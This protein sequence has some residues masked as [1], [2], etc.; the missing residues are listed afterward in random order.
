MAAPTAVVQLVP[1][2]GGCA[3]VGVGRVIGV[4]AH[5]AIQLTVGHGS[6]VQLRTADTEPWVEYAASV[7]TSRQPHAMDAS[8]TGYGA[9]ILVEPESR[10]G[11]MLA[12]LCGDRAIISVE[13]EP[14]AAAT[15]A[16]FESWLV[17]PGRA[18]L[19][20][21]IWN[22][23][24]AI[25]AGVE[26]VVV[27]D[28]R[29]LRAVAF[30]NGN[31]DKTLTLDAVAAEAF[32]SPSRFRHLFVEQAGMGLRP[33][34]L[35]RRFMKVWELS[36]RGESLSTAAHAAGFADSAHLTRTSWQMFGLP[37]SSFH[38]VDE[39]PDAGAVKH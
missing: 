9:V 31:L 21:G 32:L 7:T 20:A 13:S 8:D 4:H 12:A 23:I 36:Q 38:V 1:W 28:E 15:T 25:T 30:V 10:A 24:Q 37:P 29:I 17:A 11:Q 6:T 14:L 2:D 16:F 33:Y 27:T 22:M 35:W 39:V 5:H 19:V 3:L 34:V 18:A 26:P